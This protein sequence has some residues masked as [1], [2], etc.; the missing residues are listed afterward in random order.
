MTETGPDAIA[1]GR[2]DALAAGVARRDPDALA[3]C[4]EEIA[5]ALFRYLLGLCGDR[6]LA[7][8]LVEETFLELVEAAPTLTGGLSGVRAWLFRA[9]KNNLIDARR[10]SAR[11][12]DVALDDDFAASRPD[13]DPGP[14][15]QAE[16]HEQQ[17]VLYGAMAQVS[18]DQ[19]EVL[20]LR[21]VGGLSGPEVAEA[22]GRTVGA[23]KS[24]QHRGLA[25]LARLLGTDSTVLERP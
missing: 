14:E 4:Y 2:D 10:K 9:G 6:V 24:L 23:V 1:P 5:D 17:A 21:F 15:A 12:G 20:M 16:A 8:D 3:S 19:R 18:A 11:R 22:T 7:E 25:A 13:R